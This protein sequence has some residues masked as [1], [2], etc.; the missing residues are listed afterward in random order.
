MAAK[1]G[2]AVI[3]MIMSAWAV[4][5]LLFFG[6]LCAQNSPMIELDNE[7]QKKDAAWGC[8]GSAIL[9][10]LTFFGAYRVKNKASQPVQ[11]RQ[12]MELASV[13]RGDRM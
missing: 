9:Y 4:P 3:C 11:A 8:F 7:A 13:S 10:G 6:V 12:V 1:D 5:L 2:C